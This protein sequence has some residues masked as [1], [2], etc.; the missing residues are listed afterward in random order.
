MVLRVTVD[1]YPPAKSEAKSIFASTHPH[2]DRVAR[3]LTACADVLASSGDPGLGSVPLGL[4]VYVTG[5]EELR[6]DATNFLGGVADVLQNKM[7]LDLPH[8]GDLAGVHLFDDD[9][10]LEE[11][12]YRWRRGDERSYEVRLYRLDEPGRAEH[13]RETAELLF[14]AER[15]LSFL[16]AH[17][18]DL[19]AA[20]SAAEKSVDVPEEVQRPFDALLM[21]FISAKEQA[22]D[23]LRLGSGR[24]D[25]GPAGQLKTGLA[26]LPPR[27]RQRIQT[28]FDAI[29]V[30]DANDIRNLSVH[31]AYEKRLRDDGLWHVQEPR[32]GRGVSPRDIA[33]Y[34]SAVSAHGERLRPIIA[35]LREVLHDVTDGS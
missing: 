15:R 5:P 35:D 11:V 34:A 14:A 30:A 7:R 20:L 10:Q 33:S 19:L 22:T 29:I 27:L 25:R 32:H 26:M 9:R 8:L 13:R 17:Y 31:D 21:T 4:D 16:G 28:W 23:A 2:S 12:F 3:L 24:A 1:G 18:R 6:S